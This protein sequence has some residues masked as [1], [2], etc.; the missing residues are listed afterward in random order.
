MLAA[1]VADGTLRDDV[2][3]QDVSASLAGVILAAG[4]P[5]QATR[6]LDLLIEGMRAS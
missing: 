4:G 6:M 2:R 3:P 1:G 5:T